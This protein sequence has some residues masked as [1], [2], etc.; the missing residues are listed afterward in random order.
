MKTV[1]LQNTDIY[2]VFIN[3]RGEKESFQFD[4]KNSLT[5]SGELIFTI[6]QEASTRILNFENKSFYINSIINGTETNIYR[7]TFDNSDNYEK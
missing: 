1:N 6:P 4:K 5:E 3:N 7:G 2:I